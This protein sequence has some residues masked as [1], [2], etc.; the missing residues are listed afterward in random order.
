[1]SESIKQQTK[2][3]I[4]WSFVE[5]FSVQGVQFLIMIVMARLL[6]P[7]DYGIIGMLAI[8]LAISQSL[9]DSGFSQALIRKQNRTEIDNSTVFYFNIAVGALLYAILFFVAPYVSD[10]Y[11]EP[12]LTSVMRWVSVVVFINSLIVVQRA[13]L[14]ANIDFKTQ[15]QASL[16]AAIISGTIGIALAYKGYGVWALVYQQ[17]INA[18]INAFVLWIKSAWRPIFAYS[19][20]SFTSLFSFGSKL[21]ISGLLDTIYKNI[22]GLVI[23]KVYS[24]SSLGHYTRA[25]HFAEYPSSNITS[26]ISRVTFPILCKIQDEEDRL[27]DVYRRFIK[28]FA[29]VVFPLMVGLSAVS[30]PFIRLVIGPQW[31]FCATLLQIIC[32]NMM[33]YP[34]HAINLNLLQVKGR[35]DLFLKL[36]IIKK[37]IGVII[38]CVTI[39][40]GVEAMCYG[41]IVCSILCLAVNTFYTGKLI[42]VGFFMQMRDLFPTLLLSC[43]M[44]ALIRT[45]SLFISNDFY[46]LII[47]VLVG[48]IY[49]ILIS[50]ILK[51]PELSEILNIFAKKHS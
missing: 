13:Q 16:F 44:F 24:A 3:G 22:Y 51:F 25:A 11:K 34:I 40:L 23:G 6:S 8:F 12:I 30:V 43:S 18:V 47:G 31:A 2:S 29:Y 33:W 28:L 27:R 26:V 21:L 10:F 46:Q 20:T 48:A 7:N 50:K 19:W 17:I 4:L 35:S 9:I 38:I 15:A 14:T 41:G 45:L 49:Y 39:P 1:M 37:I 32:F 5:R 42:Q 36:E